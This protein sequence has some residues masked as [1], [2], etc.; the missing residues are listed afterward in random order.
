MRFV[1]NGINLIVVEVFK[2]IFLYYKTSSIRISFNLIFA[3][4]NFWNVTII[5]NNYIDKIHRF[6][7]HATNPSKN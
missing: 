3:L 2:M 1:R 4:G 7:K 5:I 6:G